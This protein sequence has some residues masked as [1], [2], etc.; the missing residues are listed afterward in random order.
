MQPVDECKDDDDNC[1]TKET[2]Q[3]V[4]RDPECVGVSP[5]DVVDGS[6]K[7]SRKRMRFVGEAREYCSWSSSNDG[8]TFPTAIPKDPHCHHI[9][10][11]A[12]ASGYAEFMCPSCR[13]TYCLA[14]LREASERILEHGSRYD[15]L[16]SIWV[17][18]F[19]ARD[20]EAAEKDDQQWEASTRG[21]DKSATN[22][23]LNEHGNDASYRHCKKRLRA[24][25]LDLEG[26]RH[27][28]VIWEQELRSSNLK[29]ITAA[30]MTIPEVSV[31]SPVVKRST[32]PVLGMYLDTVNL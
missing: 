14:N 7:G 4:K 10:H 20:E 12:Y 21:N 9:Q 24:L 1:S 16:E 3:G 19:T 23:R 31:I 13:L 15:W 25:L 17:N 8:P 6:Y 30:E 29:R 22:I 2:Q 11:H 32:S 26:L 27:K 18:Y 5:N 28:Q